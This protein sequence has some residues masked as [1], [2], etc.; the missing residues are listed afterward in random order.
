MQERTEE[1]IITQAPIVVT[2]GNHKYDIKPLTLGKAAKWRAKLTSIMAE[3]VNPM[4]AEPTDTNLNKA[5]I[6]ALVAF[7]E[8]VT[9]LVFLYAPELP[10]ETILAEATEEQMASAFSAVMVVAYPFLMPLI[11]SLK[12]AKSQQK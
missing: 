6:A 5:M 3:V 1:Q 10:Q 11:L 4:S 9:E 12:V 8:K 2:L 7:P